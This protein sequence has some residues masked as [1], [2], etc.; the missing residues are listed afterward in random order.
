MK[1]L[2]T[3]VLVN[4]GDVIASDDWKS[5]HEAYVRGIESIDNPKG[6]GKLK[7]RPKVKD[8]L[9]AKGN[10][11]WKRNGVGYLKSR[12]ASHMVK[13]E[14]WGAEKNF[15]FNEKITPPK[16]TLF[17]GNNEHVEP[18]AATFSG[19]DLV[20]TG[21]DGTRVAVEWETGNI[22]SSHRSLNKLGV[23]L[24]NDVID[25]GVLIVPSRAL[26]EHLTDRI[27]NISELS[28]Y[29]DV[30]HGLASGIERG[31]LAITV[32]E[33]DEIVDKDDVTVKYLKV[34]LDGRANEAK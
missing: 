28:H 16:L 6:S 11:K 29:L 17:P 9:T 10:I 30:W 24:A 25:A 4:K 14:G 27:G 34:G 3:I 2:R 5:H 12:F 31:L 32:V 33:H 23:A 22:S 21:K 7:L 26:Y 8:G 13:N 20:Q 18:I 15:G 19:F 1:W